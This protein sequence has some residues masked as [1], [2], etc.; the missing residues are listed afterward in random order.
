MLQINDIT[1]QRITTIQSLG[2]DG[3]LHDMLHIQYMVR[4]HGPFYLD[5]PAS[6]FSGAEV[7]ARIMAAA[8]ELLLVLE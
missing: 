5:T 8:T 1:V 3:T 2:A 6:G 4:D 7:K